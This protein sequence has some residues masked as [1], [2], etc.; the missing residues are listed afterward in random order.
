[1]GNFDAQ[2]MYLHSNSVDW[3]NTIIYAYT[4]KEENQLLIEGEKNKEIWAQSSSE[5][6]KW[7]GGPA[8]PK[9]DSFKL[10]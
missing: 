6:K 10:R 3:R 8:F 4:Q 2:N 9:Q 7:K 1:M 5:I